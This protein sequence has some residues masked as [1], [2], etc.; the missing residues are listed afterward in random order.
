M[1]R[2]VKKLEQRGIAGVCIADRVFPKKNSFIE[3]HR[4]R[5]SDIEECCGK[6]K[7]GKD[8]QRD[9]EFCGVSGSF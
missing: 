5:L 1:R 2:L 4:Q 7:A 9:P 8:S 6:I 3:G